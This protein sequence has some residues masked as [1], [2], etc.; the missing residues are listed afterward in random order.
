M[1]TINF[2]FLSQIYQTNLSVGV[3]ADF[4]FIK[5]GYWLPYY[6]NTGW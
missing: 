5:H 4:N 3:S 2:R 1:G 6:N